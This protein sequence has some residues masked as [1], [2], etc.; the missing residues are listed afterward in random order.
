MITFTDQPT[1]PPYPAYNN[2][3][4]RFK[5]TDEEATPTISTITVGGVSFEV[6]PDSNGEFYFNFKNIIPSL[7]NKSNFADNVPPPNGNWL[8]TDPDLY[9]ELTAEFTFILEEGEPEE[10][11]MTLPFLKSVLQKGQRRHVNSDIR[12]LDHSISQL[13]QVT[14]FEGMPFDVSIYSDTERE[15]T[16]RNA[17]TQMQVTRT[18]EKGVNRLFISSGANKA[19]ESFENDVPLYIGVNDLEF[20]VDGDVRF[21]LQVDKKPAEC[22]QL[23]KW[24]NP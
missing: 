5:V 14:Y 15:V 11:S 20:I 6:Y 9:H 18:F 22:G 2:T 16:I 17:K 4:V 12:P 24:F 10:A 19:P 21:T 3:V 23:L 13:S 1:H 8:Q 7:I